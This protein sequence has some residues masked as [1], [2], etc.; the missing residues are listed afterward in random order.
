MTRRIKTWVIDH[1]FLNRTSFSEPHI[2]TLTHSF[3]ASDLF[4][5]RDGRHF[6]ES[7]RSTGRCPFSRKDKPLFMQIFRTFYK[8]DSS[9]IDWVRKGNCRE[10]SRDLFA[11]S[12]SFVFDIRFEQR[13]FLNRKAIYPGSSYCD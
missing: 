11:P 9:L 5:N 13:S 1:Q 10:I 3:I 12:L 6:Y 4:A 2:V 7:F 8:I